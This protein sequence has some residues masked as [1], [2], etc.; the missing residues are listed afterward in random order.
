M[1]ES[2]VYLVPGGD[3]AAEFL[4]KRSRF[5]GSI[6]YVDTEEK[7]LGQIKDL[8]ARHHDA[9]HNVYAYIMRETGIMRCSDD[10]EPQGTA[11][12]PVLEVLRREK[13]ADVLVVVTRYFG[14]VLLGAGG[15]TRAYARAAK[16]AVE[17][18][19][20]REMQ[21]WAAFEL[22]CPYP[23]FEPVKREL[24]HLGGAVSGVQYGEQ[25]TLDVLLPKKTAEQFGRRLAELSG[26][27]LS[28][29]LKGETIRSVC[30]GECSSPLF[31]ADMD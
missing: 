29:V 14:G 8:R 4:E 30:Q 21:P 16:E 31:P 1:G 15:L 11:G 7:A 6:R 13:L 10:G 27:R 19:G 18:V 5:I 17:A 28:A 25:I 24:L 22:F 20:V 26:G 9:K 3:G 23:Y 12:M 2:S